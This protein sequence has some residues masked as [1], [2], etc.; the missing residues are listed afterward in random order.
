VNGATTPKRIQ[1]L[2]RAMELLDWLALRPDGATAKEVAFGVDIPLPT[3]YRLFGALT[4]QR[5]VRR[6]QARTWV[7]GSGCLD[8]RSSEEREE[9]DPRIDSMLD[10]ILTRL[11]ADEEAAAT[12][13]SWGEGSLRVR[14]AVAAPTAPLAIDPEERYEF[15]HAR[16]CGKVMLAFAPAERREAH[17]SAAPLRPRTPETLIDRDALRVELEVIRTTGVSVDREEY[18]AGIKC[19]ARPIWVDGAVWAAIGIAAGAEGWGRR[20]VNRLERLRSA[21]QFAGQLRIG[22]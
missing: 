14:S 12:V 1:S 9:A 7:L 3:V 19:V 20:D 5:L 22:S 18:V 8:L 17:L 2:S 16:A 15:A 4:D 10:S 13:V 11:I 21:A 6:T